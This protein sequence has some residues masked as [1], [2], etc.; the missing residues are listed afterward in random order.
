LS[1]AK[2][3]FESQKFRIERRSFERQGHEHVHDIVMHPGAAVVLPVLEDGAT[4]ANTRVLLI[5]NYRAAVGS[6]LLEIPAGTLDPGESPEACAARELAEETGYRPGRLVPLV[7][8]Y[9]S[10]GIMD[11]RLCAFL[12]TELTPGAASPDEGEEIRLA[13]MMLVEAL[14]AIHTGRI[15]DGKTI[16]TL[17]YYE[18]YVRGEARA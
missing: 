14:D 13:P 3:V 2:I 15:Q 17:L 4:P 16:L 18:R 7:T 1:R 11:E 9:S 8:F 5:H 10:P 12:A 6:E